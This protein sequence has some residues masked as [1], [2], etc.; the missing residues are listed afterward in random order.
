M[1]SKRIIG[2]VSERIVGTVVTIKFRTGVANGLVLD[3]NKS[4]GVDI[5][6]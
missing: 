1:V 2:T 3:L 5:V 4:A 6:Y